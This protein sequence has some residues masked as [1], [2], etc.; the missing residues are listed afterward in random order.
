M[1]FDSDDGLFYKSVNICILRLVDKFP[2]F[3]RF[4]KSNLHDP[5]R[6]NINWR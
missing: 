2:K 3:K 6:V 5:I 4:L 1:C